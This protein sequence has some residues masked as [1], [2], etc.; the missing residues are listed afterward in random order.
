MFLGMSINSYFQFMQ[1]NLLMLLEDL[2]LI[3][4]QNVLSEKW[5]IPTQFSIGSWSFVPDIFLSMDRHIS[6]GAAGPP[7]LIFLVSI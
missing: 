1:E 6:K 5:S 3:S 4:S 7:D 2:P